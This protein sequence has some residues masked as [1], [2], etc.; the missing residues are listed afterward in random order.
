MA[1]RR[2][3][4]LLSFLSGGRVGKSL[5]SSLNATLKASTRT[6][7]RVACAMRYFSVARLL[8]LR[9]SRDMVPFSWSWLAEVTDPRILPPPWV[10]AE[11][12]LAADDLDLTPGLTWLRW[13]LGSGSCLTIIRAVRACDGNAYMSCG[14]MAWWVMWW[15]GWWGWWGGVGRVSC[16]IMWQAEAGVWSRFIRVLGMVSEYEL[17]FT[18]LEINGRENHMSTKTIGNDPHSASLHNYAT[19]DVTNWQVIAMHALM[20]WVPDSHE[21]R[22]AFTELLH[23]LADTFNLQL[24]A[25]SHMQKCQNALLATCSLCPTLSQHCTQ[26]YAHIV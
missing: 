26:L 17:Q 16:G 8:R 2:I 22:E 6:R 11:E 24:M 5:R 14:V 20:E 13:S 7:S 23:H 3:S 10:L 15:V 9:S 21:T 4:I 1:K 19:G 25:N 12:V 18:N